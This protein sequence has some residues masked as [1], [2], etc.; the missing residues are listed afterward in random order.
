MF[1]RITEP[2]SINPSLPFFRVMKTRLLALLALSAVTS[3][4]FAA[5]AKLEK[6]VFGAGCFWCVEAF[7]EQQPGVTD[8]VSGYAGGE[9]SN[10]TYEQVSAGRTS[11]AEVVEVTF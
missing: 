8:V 10:P 7:F 4:A 11:H 3:S 2:M 1:G 5:D 6:A 9:E